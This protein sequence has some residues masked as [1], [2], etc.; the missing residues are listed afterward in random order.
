MLRRILTSLFVGTFIL[1]AFEIQKN[2]NLSYQAS[3]GIWQNQELRLIDP[4][5]TDPEIV[6]DIIAVST[7][8]YSNKFQIRVDFPT[9]TAVTKCQVGFIFHLPWLQSSKSTEP[10]S[11]IIN[12]DQNYLVAN[13]PAY[14]KHFYFQVYAMNLNNTVD[15]T[16]KISHFQTPPSPIRIQVWVEDFNFGNTPIQALRRWDGA[17]TGPN[18][19]RHGLVQL[20][21]GMQHYKIPIVFQDFATISN[22][23]ALHQL[24]GGMLFQSLQKQNLLWINFTNKNGNDYSRLKSSVTQQLFSESNIKLTPIYN[25]SNVP[26]SDDP[27]SQDGMSSSLLNK[28]FNQYFLDKQNGTFIIRVPFSA[29]IL[30][31]DSYSTKLFSYLINH[32]WLE[33]VSPDEQDNLDLRIIQESSKL[34]PVSDSH[35]TELQDRISNNQGPF[36]LQAL[37]MMESAFDDS[38][39]LFILMN[40]QYLNQIG[41]FLE[42]NLWAEELQPVSTCTRDIDQDRVNECILANE[43]NFLIIELDGG[44]IPFAATHQ[45]GNYFALIGTSSQ[46]AYGLGPPS[47]W[48]TT[49]GIFMDP[50]EIPGAISDSQ[51]LFSNYSAKQLSESSLQLTSA[52]GNTTKIITIS[53]QGIQITVK[54]AVPSALTIPVIFSPECMTH[55]G[56]PY[57]FQMYQNVSQSYIRL[58]CEHNVIRLQANQPVHSISFLEAYLGQQPGENPNISYPLMFYQKTGLTQFIIQ[59]HPVLEIYIITNQYK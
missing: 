6:C 41:Y 58:Q 10:G 32:P 21:N 39:D 15:S 46:I 43:S 26:I 20:L 35:L 13:F 22:L 54:S 18:G 55:P 50:Q 11:M 4:M 59:A 57:L 47:E 52:D 48:N 2:K 29:T 19:Q 37:K 49:S 38:S 27:F 51:D 17:H 24:N 34:T 30:A 36:T 7:K 40:Q 42:A 28:L 53:D 8:S 56:W 23:Q 12:T 31:D 44:R 16:E 3:D 1:F 25:F 9:S 5:Q 33:V 45:N 14:F